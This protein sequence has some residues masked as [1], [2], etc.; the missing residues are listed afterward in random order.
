MGQVKVNRDVEV[1][2]VEETWWSGELDG[3]PVEVHAKVYRCDAGKWRGRF[4]ASVHLHSV[5]KGHLMA[6]G[7]GPKPEDLC[8]AGTRDEAVQK[9]LIALEARDDLK[10]K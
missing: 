9:A 3:N 8:W 7:G 6:Y 5:G 10:V 2:L 4:G 1:S